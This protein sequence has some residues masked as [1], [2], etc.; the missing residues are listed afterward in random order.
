MKRIISL[1][2]FSIAL[3]IS[4]FAQ[5]KGTITGTVRL[6][7][8]DTVI[9]GATVKI[10]ELK[11]T[12]VTAT[13]GTYT[14]NNVPPGRYTVIAHQEGFKDATQTID[15]TAAGTSTADFRLQITGV[16]EQV[17]VT[18]TGS[19]TAVGESIS[20]VNVMDSSQI[21]TRAAVGLGDVLENEPGVAKRSM[22]SGDSRPVIRGFDGDRVKVAADGISVGSLASQ[23]GDHAEPVDTLSV[24][25]IEVVKGPATLLYG[26]NAI[27]GVVNAV[28]GHDEGEHPGLRAYVSGIGGTNN[29]QAAVSGGFEY[30]TGPWMFWSNFS[31]Q[32]TGDY[33]AGGNFG[34]VHNTFANSV[35]GQT[36][37]GYFASKAFFTTNFNYYQSRYGIPLDPADPTTLRSLRMHRGDLKFNF[38]F[39]NLAS[40]I[41]GAKFTVD[42]SRYQHQEMENGSVG[43]TFRNYVDSLRGVFE[44][45]KMKNVSGRFGFE[46]FKRY[47]STIGNEV[48]VAG[49]V[50]QNM[51]SV[52]GLEEWTHERVTLQ[53]GGRLEHN[54]YNPENPALIDRSFTGFSGAI[55]GKVNLWKGGLF[56]ANFSH[57]FRAP[58]LEELYNHGPHDGTLAF[59]VGNVNLKPETSNGLDFSLRH[60]SGR[61]KGEANFYH[62]QFKNY[63]FLAPRGTFDP[64]SGLEFADYLQS[65]AR[66]WGTELS[67]DITLTK[68]LN[69]ITG[70]DY[71][72]AQLADGRPIPRISPARLRFGPDFHYKNFDVKP[73]FVA[74][75]RQ[76]RVFT[77][78]TPT[79]GYGT[80]NLTASYVIGGKHTAQIFSVNAYNL[81]NKLYFNHIS[82]IKDI[83]PEIGRGVRFTYTVRYF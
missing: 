29:A 4:V 76:N 36:G 11:Q 48:L 75:G 20:S 56:V 82:F 43:T 6:P 64:G 22:G 8:E 32:R 72:N 12:T 13:D 28:S 7:N 50:R 47:F 9:H 40:F 26:S 67:A 5:G 35:T 2:I 65:D 66:Y 79:A 42:L 38:G 25:R 53:F 68:Y 34:R 69:L 16:Q 81:N 23:S 71:V 80:A 19:E 70:F 18:A 61:F 30:G 59:E 33:H 60:Q 17:T 83:S 63:V 73:E 62:Y 54:G 41:T 52:F 24:E 3:A 21:T 10:A 77:N 37:F 15:V 74:V 27:G 49:P 31:G 1:F 55:G 39:N 45:R 78:E 46:T 44:E 57:G 14:F 51:S 58:A